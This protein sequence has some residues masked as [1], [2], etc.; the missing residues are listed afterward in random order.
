MFYGDLT[1]VAWR[2]VVDGGAL[3]LPFPETFAEVL[4]A[5]RK[6][7]IAAAHSERTIEARV[8]TLLRLS[9]AVLDPLEA[10]GP[11]LVSWLAG[12]VDVDGN[13]LKRSSKSTYR[14]HLRS[15]YQWLVL[16][17]RRADDPSLHLPRPRAPR[18]VPH[19]LSS[20]QVRAA[21]MACSDPRARW[22]RA[23]I[24]LAAYAGFRAHEIAKVRGE[25]FAGAEIRVVGKG[26]VASTVPMHPMIAALLEEFPSTG[27]WF[28][29]QS[30]RG[31]VSRSSVSTAIA[32]AF[33]RAGIVGNVPHGL[34][35]HFCTEV[36]R[37]TK[38]DLRTTQRAA[39]HASPATTA[40]Y[41]LV[42]DETLTNAVI[43][44]PA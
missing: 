33:K 28:P 24:V 7:G 41:T 16:D 2:E 17:G 40:I 4:I 32:R 37:A 21:L 42:A 29:S 39:R 19:P 11:E 26:G 36:L 43:A 1:R 35:H 31:C 23:Y 20:V 25:D 10:T 27:Y 30:S 44:I 18:G 13:P 34:R 9:A 3:A 5:F 6:H 12:L 38:G 15:F 8:G 14:S 22:T